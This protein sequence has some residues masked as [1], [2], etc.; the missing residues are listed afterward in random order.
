M[1]ASA[2]EG[3]WLC[4]TRFRT[5]RGHW[6]AV[7]S[8]SAPAWKCAALDRW[9]ARSVGNPYTSVCSDVEPDLM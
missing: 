8:F 5:W 9:I 7:L 4:A 3:Q 6:L 2:E 1:M